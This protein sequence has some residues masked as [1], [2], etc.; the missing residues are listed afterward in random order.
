VNG[1]GNADR[2]AGSDVAAN[3]MAAF[4]HGLDQD[5]VLMMGR[6]LGP[7]PL[8]PR[9]R[10]RRA[11]WQQVPSAV[12]APRAEPGIDVDR[13]AASRASLDCRRLRHQLLNS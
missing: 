4:R 6:C 9:L 10:S 13:H 8:P 5:G 3:L 2:E 1:N 12:L 11:G 7:A